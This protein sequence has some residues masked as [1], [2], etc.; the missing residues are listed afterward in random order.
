DAFPGLKTYLSEQASALDFPGIQERVDDKAPPNALTGKKFSLNTNLVGLWRWEVD[1]R[2]LWLMQLLAIDGSSASGYGALILRDAPRRP[3]KAIPFPPPAPPDFW[4]GSYG[5]T[6]H[7][8]RIKPQLF[9]N[10]Y[11][12][13]ASVS[14]GTIAVYDVKRAQPKLIIHDIPQRDLL[15]EVSL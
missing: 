6:P 12:V 11:L 7:Q 9:P 15:R 13:A 3:A 2:A 1:G 5:Q 10:G 4:T 14:S 8:T